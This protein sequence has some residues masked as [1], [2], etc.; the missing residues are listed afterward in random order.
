MAAFGAPEIFTA[1][2]ADGAALL[3]MRLTGLVWIAPVFSSK[4]VPAKAKAALLLLLMLIMWPA[5]SVS[6]VP[7]AQFTLSAGLR[8]ALIGLTLG[9]GAAIFVAAAEAAGDMLAVLMAL[10]GANVVDPMSKTQLPILGH[11]LGMT[12]LTMILATGGHLVILGALHD[13]LGVMP[14]G[15]EIRVQEGTLAVVELGG[16][17]LLL[18]LKFAAPVMGAIMM[19]H[20]ALGI[21]AR[22]VPQLNVLMV[23]FPVQIG[24]GLFMLAATIPFLA[25]AFSDWPAEYSGIAS[26]LLSRLAPAGGR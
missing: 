3:L 23:A 24:L 10:S 25:S 18:G 21:L 15:G 13:S 7:G 8:E 19:G 22:T 11:L 4:V 20:T 9:F 16:M 1:A 14:L 26:D 2:G 17:L 6:I 5:A 12:V